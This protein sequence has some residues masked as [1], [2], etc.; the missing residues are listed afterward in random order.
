MI[1]GLVPIGGVIA[2]LKSFASVPS[3][4]T[5]G[6]TEYVECGG[7]T[8]SDA[9][10]IF[11]TVSMPALNNNNKFL[12]GQATSGGTGGT[13]STHTHPMA[14]PTLGFATN[15]G[16]F[17]YSASSGLVTGATDGRPSFY[18]VVWLWRIK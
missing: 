15:S 17:G 16:G 14:N 10:S 2:Y 8:L 18:N 5:Q 7:A 11:N 6:R 12:R 9:Q 4:A 1:P 3:L 13:D